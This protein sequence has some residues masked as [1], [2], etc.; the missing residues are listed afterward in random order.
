[1]EESE[2]RFRVTFDQ[3]AV[4]IAHLATDGRWLRVNQKLCDIVGYTR[5]ELLQRAFQDVTY[6]DD[7]AADSEN[8]RR[9]LAGEIQTYSMQKRYIQKTGSL[10][11]VH[12]SVS[13]ARGPQNEPRYFIS[14]VEDITE[15][16]RLE[17][18]LRQSQKM[19]AIGR[20]AGG[21]AHDF[22]NLL[23]VIGGYGHMMLSQ[24]DKQDSLWE[25]AEAICQSSDRAAALT[26][27]L[28]A[29]SRRQIVQ[30]R[31]VN[32]NDLVGNMEGMLR[33]LLG[34]NIALTI[35][36][37]A[38]P[39]NVKVDPGQIEQVIVN[40][41]VNARDAMPN[42]GK[43]T[44]EVSNLG[45]YQ[46]A[47]VMLTVRDTGIGMDSEVQSHLFEPF[48]TTKGREKGTGLGLS[49]VYGIVKQA[50]GS[51][52][53]DT[54]LGRGTAFQIFFQNVPDSDV[55]PAAVKT[56]GKIAVGSETI[57]LVEDEAPLRK[58]AGEVLRSSGYTVLEACTGEDAVRMCH[59]L[60]RPIPLL[61]TDMIMPGMNG[62]MLAERL[63][64]SW[65]EMKVL[66]ISGYTENV[67]DP[68]G[69]LDPATSYLQKPFA[70][71]VLAQKVRELLDAPE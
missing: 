53:V 20:L 69:P 6:P 67:L 4:G 23:T 38:L 54:Q 48:Y 3:A 65:P 9:M 45:G 49:I 7:L 70:P 32:M 46:P 66:Y 52:T 18:Q 62:R 34:E 60:P 22:N 50:G 27:Q 41:A 5:E 1:L 36:L 25:M 44:I 16:K 40:L 56:A 47:Q 17:E 10:I 64:G 15:T 12:I 26:R 29:F 2:E 63:R 31:I 43:L 58:M 19:E 30:S 37:S 35:I 13:L 21:I 42:G 33:R 24:L 55:Q 28:L 39:G 59:G 8:V 11:W 57:L 71:A 14:I 68:H 61:V 51:I